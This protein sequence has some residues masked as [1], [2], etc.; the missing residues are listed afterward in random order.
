MGGAAAITTVSAA[1]HALEV[2]RTRVFQTGPDFV[3]RGSIIPTLGDGPALGAAAG[4]GAAGAGV[5]A[6]VGDDVT[7][8]EIVHPT[9]T[10]ISGMDTPTH[11]TLLGCM[12]TSCRPAGWLGPRPLLHPT[13]PMAHHT[14]P[15]AILIHLGF[16]QLRASRIPTRTRGGRVAM[17]VEGGSLLP[18]T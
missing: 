1:D 8:A 14:L 7:A 15:L 12:A 10:A 17:V 6:E 5:V 16:N 9:L 18:W 3:E 11:P 2:L 13:D 4:E